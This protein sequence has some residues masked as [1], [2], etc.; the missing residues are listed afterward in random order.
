MEK[1]TSYIAES[2]NITPNQ[3]KEMLKS[4][5]LTDFDRAVS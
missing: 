4:I 2:Q 3:A 1:A 5:I